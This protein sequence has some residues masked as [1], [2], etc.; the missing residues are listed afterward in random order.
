MNEQMTEQE[1]MLWKQAKKRVD[2]RRHLFTYII[3]NGFIWAMYLFGMMGG[4]NMNWS[5][6]TMAGHM[7]HFHFPWPM[8]MTLGWGIG[9]AFNFYGA[10]V[11]NKYTAVEKEY[12]KLKNSGK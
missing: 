8:F 7:H 12:E 9:L 5:D 11:D 1:R 6:D 3:V 2:F 10:Y 4:N